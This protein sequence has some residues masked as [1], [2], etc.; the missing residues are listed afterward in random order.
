MQ[1]PHPSPPTMIALLFRADDERVAPT[2]A[3]VDPG[4]LF[5]REG[6]ASCIHLAFPCPAGW[7]PWEDARFEVDED[8]DPRDIADPANWRVNVVVRHAA[9]ARAADVQCNPNLRVFG[10]CPALGNAFVSLQAENVAVWSSFE[11]GPYHFVRR[12]RVDWA[13]DGVEALVPE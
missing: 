9:N 3:R 2:P 6:G 5:P 8:E 1:S 12:S 4:A 7:R 13:R 11:I 10:A